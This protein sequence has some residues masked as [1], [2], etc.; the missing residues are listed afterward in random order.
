MDPNKRCRY[1]NTITIY[2]APET[3]KVY[4]V[5]MVNFHSPKK[6]PRAPFYSEPMVA[7][8]DSASPED[9]NM[10]L[11]AQEEPSAALS[12]HAGSQ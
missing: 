3:S 6:K 4:T 11:S 10:V 5:P 1:Y 8:L 2:T 9:E 12:I 7:K